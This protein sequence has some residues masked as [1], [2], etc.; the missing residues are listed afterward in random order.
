VKSFG[1]YAMLQ[2]VFA[3]LN[4]PDQQQQAAAAE[5]YTAK[6]ILAHWDEKRQCFPASFEGKSKA[7]IIP[8]IEGLLYP[9]AMGLTSEVSTEGPNANLIQQLKT[10]LNTVLVPGVCIDPLSKGWNLS[11]TSDNTWQSKVYLNQYV[12]ENVLGIKSDTTGHDADAAQLAYQV[13]GSPAVGWSDKFGTNT[14]TA[15]GSRHYPRGVTTALW[16]LWP[17]LPT[18][19]PNNSHTDPVFAKY[20]HNGLPDINQQRLAGQPNQA[21]NDTGRG[22][23]DSRARLGNSIRRRR[24]D[25]LAF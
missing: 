11:S 6:S 20:F 16:W 25:H 12:A 23:G 15:F 19:Y 1:C 7:M 18:I 3:A 5:A 24:S 14:H 8:A 4:E 17:G 13:L 21:G 2:P 22:G 10:H 9:F